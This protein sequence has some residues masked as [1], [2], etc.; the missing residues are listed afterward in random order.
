MSLLN[1]DPTFCEYADNSKEA[2]VA[3]RKRKCLTPTPKCQNRSPY[4]SANL[5]ATLAD[6]KMD[7]FTHV[8]RS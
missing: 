3:K 1:G 4:L 6:L 2:N 8:E 7:D 5:V